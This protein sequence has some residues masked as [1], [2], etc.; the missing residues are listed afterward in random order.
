MVCFLFAHFGHLF[1]QLVIVIHDGGPLTPKS[2][3]T[4]IVFTLELIRLEGQTLGTSL[5]PVDVM[6]H[7]TDLVSGLL[8]A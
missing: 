6:S 4:I 8:I 2:V 3:V 1:L 7:I 5:D